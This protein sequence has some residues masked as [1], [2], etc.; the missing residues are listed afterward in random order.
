MAKAG[1]PCVE[2]GDPAKWTVCEYCDGPLCGIC[3]DPQGHI[4]QCAWMDEM[5][6]CPY[7]DT[8][9]C[10]DDCLTPEEAQYGYNYEEVCK[11]L[12]NERAASGPATPDK[13]PYKRI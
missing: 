11:A 8:Y 4:D 1:D 10:L 3:Q 7:C 12:A 9:G 13:A 5:A 6:K 2:C